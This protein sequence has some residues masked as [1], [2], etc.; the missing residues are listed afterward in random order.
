MG[1][2]S[3]DYMG[4]LVGR[5]Q[6]AVDVHLHAFAVDAGIPSLRYEQLRAVYEEAAVLLGHEQGGLEHAVWRYQP[7]AV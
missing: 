2:K 6:V 1:P 5:S 7:G 4:N 3:I